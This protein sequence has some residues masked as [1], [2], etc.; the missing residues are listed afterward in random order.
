[1]NKSFKEYLE[2]FARKDQERK[3]MRIVDI[4]FEFLWEYVFDT[5]P[6]PA[7]DTDDTEKRVQATDDY[8]RQLQSIEVLEEIVKL[9][10]SG[11]LE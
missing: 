1:M 7:V 6:V 9:Y 4:S 5:A 3:L 8:M 10:K 2:E 11:K